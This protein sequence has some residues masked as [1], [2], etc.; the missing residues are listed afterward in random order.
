MVSTGFFTSFISII[1][2][3]QKFKLDIENDRRISYLNLPQYTCTVEFTNTHKLSPICGYISL[4][5]QQCYCL[6]KV[7]FITQILNKVLHIAF[8][9]QTLHCLKTFLD[10][11]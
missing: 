5:H 1:C 8:W 2:S 3:M 6:V 9:S 7:N 4:T 11:S 10:F